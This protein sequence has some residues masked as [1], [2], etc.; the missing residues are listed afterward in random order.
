MRRA[1]GIKS[2][3][4]F[5]FVILG[6]QPKTLNEEVGVLGKMSKKI[7]QNL[8]YLYSSILYFGIF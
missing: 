6:E 2:L 5:R 8:K 1:G 4:A 3:N 7:F